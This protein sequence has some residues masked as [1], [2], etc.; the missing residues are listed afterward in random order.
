MVTANEPQRLVD[1]LKAIRI[2]LERPALMTTAEFPE[3]PALLDA[4]IAEIERLE[5]DL[6]DAADRYGE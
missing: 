6:D 2:A 4:A 5:G 1:D 3:L